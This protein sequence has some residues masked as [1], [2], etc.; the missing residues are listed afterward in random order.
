MVVREEEGGGQWLCKRSGDA[1]QWLSAVAAGAWAVAGSG[2]G[3]GYHWRWLELGFPL[4]A[5]QCWVSSLS[6]LLSGFKLVP[7]CEF[8]TCKFNL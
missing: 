2:Q 1:G 5:G 7:V 6:S 8:V 4:V 3:L